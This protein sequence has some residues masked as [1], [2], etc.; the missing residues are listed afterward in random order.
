MFL[1]IFATTLLNG[2]FITNSIIV[3]TQDVYNTPFMNIAAMVMAICEAILYSQIL[4]GSVISNAL[5]LA[6][7]LSTG[8]T[9]YIQTKVIAL[10]LRNLSTLSILR[11]MPSIEIVSSWIIHWRESIS[12]IYSDFLLLFSKSSMDRQRNICER[13]FAI[14]CYIIETFAPLL[15]VYA[16]LVKIKNLEFVIDGEPFADWD[17]TQYISFVA[18]LNQV[19]GLRVLRNVE[20]SSIQHFVFSGADA[21]LDTDELLLLDDW[22]NVSVLSAVSNLHLGWY[23]NMVFW[24]GLDPQKIQLLLKNHI[25]TGSDNA[26]SLYRMVKENDHILID[27]DQMVKQKLCEK[28]P[29]YS[30]RT[31]SIL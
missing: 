23:D 21:E 16:I 20:T 10:E 29:F 8:G 14:P 27:Y 1:S 9:T 12:H 7:N 22:W 24:Y 6:V 28:D 3:A 15:A 19:A 18:F 2:Y 26:Q 5:S 13:I 25:S 11:Y 4:F 30:S 17:L 31:K